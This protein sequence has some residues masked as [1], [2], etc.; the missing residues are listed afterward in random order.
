MLEDY[1]VAR[2]K[3]YNSFGWALDSQ[4]NTGGTKIQTEPAQM[5]VPIYVPLESDDSTIKLQIVELIT[6]LETGG[7][8]IDS[9]H[10]EYHNGLTWKTVQGGGG[11]DPLTYTLN[12]DVLIDNLTAGQSYRFRVQ[13]HNIHG[14]GLR[15]EELIEVVSGRPDQPSPATV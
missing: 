11:T 14:W 8:A 6:V 9:Y 4:P 1:V 10:V 3:A 13:A 5:A 12:T 15:S 7:Y 2:V